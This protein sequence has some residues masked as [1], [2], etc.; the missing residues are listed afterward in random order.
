MSFEIVETAKKCSLITLLCTGHSCA[1][2]SS[3]YLFNFVLFVDF[4]RNV[5]GNQCNQLSTPSKKKQYCDPNWPAGYNWMKAKC[6]KVC[7]IKCG[8]WT[9]VVGVRIMIRNYYKNRNLI[10][11]LVIT[12][13][14]VKIYDCDLTFFSVIMTS[15]S[16]ALL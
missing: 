14:A 4:C 3:W 10:F 2:V 12:D 13:N 9:L 8:K 7:G 6:A 1:S 16:K 15:K 11:S 5:A